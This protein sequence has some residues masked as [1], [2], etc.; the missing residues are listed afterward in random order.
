MSTGSAANSARSQRLRRAGEQLVREQP[1]AGREHDP[2]GLVDRQELGGQRPAEHVGERR[3]VAP[4]SAAGR[5]PFGARGSTVSAAAVA[6]SSVSEPPGGSRGGAGSPAG[7]ERLD[8]AAEM[9]GVPAARRAV[10]RVG[11]RPDRLVRPALP[12]GEVV[13]ALVA[14]PR[15]VAD[16]VAAPAVGRPRRWTAWWYCAAA[17]SS[18]C[19]G[20]RP[21]APA[22]RAAPASAGGR[23]RARSGPRRPGRRGSGHRARGGPARASSAASSVSIQ[24]AERA[25]RDVVQ[26]VEVDRADARRRGP[27][28]P[29][30]RRRPARWRR[31]SRRS[32][33]AIQALG[34][35]RDPVDPGPC[36]R[37]RRRR[38]RP[39]PGSPRS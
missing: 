15:P 25:V 17:R 9:G 31:P 20:D 32:S 24:V 6:A 10:E 4:P 12:V 11:A 19:S 22:A 14:R 36:E 29:R 37:R 26:E 39:G 8:V 18:S 7:R 35:E 23:R 5:G 21:V 3:L 33:A 30:R 38:A 2:V 28:R 16:L 1:A 27:R 34:A 13:A